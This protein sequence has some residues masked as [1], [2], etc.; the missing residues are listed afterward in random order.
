[1]TTRISV[2]GNIGQD[3]ELKTIKSKG[4]SFK[5][6]NFTVADNQ[7][8]LEGEEWVDG[9]TVWYNVSAGGNLALLVEDQLKS[10]DL[11]DIEGTF[12][13]EEYESKSDGPKLSFNIRAIKVTTP[14]VS[15]KTE[16][17]TSRSSSR[18]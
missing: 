10:G 17:K 5:I 3:P 4:E 6:V 9:Y 8:R 7:R 16:K 1:M 15:E 14:L 11:V 13:I 18:R 2:R 12:E